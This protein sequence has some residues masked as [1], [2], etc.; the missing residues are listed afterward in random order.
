MKKIFALLLGLMMMVS[1][2]LAEESPIPTGPVDG[3]WTASA[4]PTITEELTMEHSTLWKSAM[5][6]LT[7]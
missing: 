7:I 2:A 6:R 1:S 3:G 5:A 4:D